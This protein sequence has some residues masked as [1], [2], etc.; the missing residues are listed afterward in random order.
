MEI[1]FDGRESHLYRASGERAVRAPTPTHAAW[2][3]AKRMARRQHGRRG[4]A[5]GVH[6]VG[7]SEIGAAVHYAARLVG[8]DNYATSAQFVVRRA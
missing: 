2:V 1:I 4:D 6:V 7:H 3:L 8:S 5:Y